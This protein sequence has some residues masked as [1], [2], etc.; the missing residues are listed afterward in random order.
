MRNIHSKLS[1]KSLAACKQIAWAICFCMPFIFAG[2]VTSATK[3]GSGTD[4]ASGSLEKQ[5]TNDPN[6]D[7]DR[8]MGVLRVERSKPG[9]TQIM[10]DACRGR[11]KVLSDRDAKPPQLE[12]GVAR[13]VGNSQ[14]TQAAPPYPYIRYRCED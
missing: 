1:G 10:R 12:V 13:A 9:N 7:E 4:Q 8:K 5:P 2:C 11:Y 3:P 14:G 6:E